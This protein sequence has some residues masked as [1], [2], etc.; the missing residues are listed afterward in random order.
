MPNLI[1]IDWG[2]S[3]FRAYL[4]NDSGEILS[5]VSS[6]L[7]ILHLKKDD[8]ATTLAN[9]LDRLEGEKERPDHIIRY[10]HLKK[11]LG[12]NTIRRMPGIVQ[13]AC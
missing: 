12:R 5:S 9:E 10:D 6:P 7:G 11:R 3:S 4:L 8:F 1:A 2:T 13:T